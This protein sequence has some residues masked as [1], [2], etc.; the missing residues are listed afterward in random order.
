MLIV[1]KTIIKNDIILKYEHVLLV[2][3][4]SQDF[5]FVLG[6]LIQFVELLACQGG[7][8]DHCTDLN[9]AFLFWHLWKL[10]HERQFQ[11]QNEEKYKYSGWMLTSVRS[12][13]QKYRALG[14]NTGLEE[15]LPEQHRPVN[16]RDRSATAR[17]M[18]WAMANEQLF[19]FLSPFTV[20]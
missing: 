16:H 2:K 5:V 14:I 6:F 17:W 8:N 11:I 19:T 12:Q 20:S 15:L 9:N 18:R 13:R 7:S 3:E 4:I 10:L 1:I